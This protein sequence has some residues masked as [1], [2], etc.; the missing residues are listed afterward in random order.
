M[1]GNLSKYVGA[2]IIARLSPTND[3]EATQCFVYPLF[4]KYHKM[5]KQWELI[6]TEDFGSFRNIRVN[7]ADKRKGIDFC[8]KMGEIVNIRI[9]P[10]NQAST[11]NHLELK[12]NNQLKTY[13][14]MSFYPKLGERIS[15]IWI[16][17]FKEED[18]FYQVISCNK[19]LDILKQTPSVD[20]NKIVYTSKI[21]IYN[22]N[23]SYM[24]GPFLYSKKDN[25]LDVYA[26][27]MLD[28]YINEYDIGETYDVA[29][30]RNN[31]IYSFVERNDLPKPTKNIDWLNDEEM[32]E[33]LATILK[34]CQ[35]PED[36]LN[37]INDLTSV[38]T[39]FLTPARYERLQGLLHKLNDNKKY[40][41]LLFQAVLN[42][43]D[44]LKQFLER[45]PRDEYIFKDNIYTEKLSSEKEELS[46]LNDDLKKQLNE[47]Q[48]K[49]SEQENIISDKTCEQQIAKLTEEN[50]QLKKK[51]KIQNDY[52]QILNKK[53]QLEL[54]YND[55]KNK[56]DIIK[57]A[58]NES[59]ENL[60]E[61][62]NIIAKKINAELLNK[63]LNNINSEENDKHKIKTFDTNMLTE[64]DA[65]AIIDYVEDYLKK[66]GRNV[67]H[68][69]VVNYLTCMSQ[70]FITTFAGEPG[71]G[72]TSLCGL[73]CKALGLTKNDENRRFVDISVERGWTSIKDF[74]GY[75][76][77]LTKQMEK[78]NLEMFNAI[79]T[80]STEINNEK[81][82]PY[83]VLLD[84]ANLS[85]IEHYW[86][87]FLKF[88]DDDFISSR[89]LSL[90]GEF[91]YYIPKH[92]RFLATVNFDHTTEELSPRFLD[93][94]WVITL[95]PVDIIQKQIIIDAPDKVISYQSLVKAFC[96][97]EQKDNENYNKSKN[98]WEDIK[99]V[100][101]EFNFNIMPRNLKMVDNYMLSASI[102]MNS[103]SNNKYAAVDYAV[104]QKILPLING[105]GE[106]Y[107]KLIDKLINEECFDM[108][109]TNMHLQR[110]KQNAE[111]NMG[112]FQFFAR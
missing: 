2:E 106:N 74:I 48:I 103:T 29:D 73:L 25:V 55:Y 40:V 64:L 89:K 50:E 81:S 71:T 52:E 67:S 104:S 8:D 24:Y 37:F 16:E 22:E 84:E 112:Y 59:I 57:T 13:C 38:Q 34:T 44:M 100:F 7:L 3:L 76:N 108:P 92:L 110:I 97:F 41:S 31:K 21:L 102:Y 107:S 19:D 90:G 105:I 5:K 9:N 45:I 54:E 91:D 10:M 82:A 75:F 66:S 86:A 27:K 42:D 58:I 18:S 17:P 111:Q 53:Q 68:N 26:D 77:P 94:S 87:N 36:K 14:Y 28:Q 83:F 93:R 69:D 15:Q 60:S 95:K 49:L 47:L 32:L 98:K 46:N 43:S 109:M 85:S 62:A 51:I 79:E 20:Y 88:C 23:T 12:I 65:E 80:L 30:E 1:V 39:N 11:E 33:N 101:K 70:G 4:I 56:L 63:V 96:N 78:S 61:E 35:Y 72:K 6:N 99:K